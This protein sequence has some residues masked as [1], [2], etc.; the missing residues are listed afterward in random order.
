MEYKEPSIPKELKNQ[1]GKFEGYDEIQRLIE[2]NDNGLEFEPKNETET[3]I[4]YKLNLPNPEFDLTSFLVRVRSAVYKKLLDEIKDKGSFRFYLVL[5]PTMVKDS[6]D[7]K[8]KD[9]LDA[10]FPGMSSK[11]Q[12]VMTP[13]N[14]PDKVKNAYDKIK[15]SVENFVN[16]GSNWRLFSVGNIELVT[17]RYETGNG[18]PTEVRPIYTPVSG[19][20]Y[21]PSPKWIADKKAVVNVRNE[22]NKCFRWALKSALFPVQKHSCRTSQYPCNSRDGLDFKGFEFPMYVS[23]IPKFEKRNNLAINVFGEDKWSLKA[24]K[25]IEENIEPKM[26]IPLHYSKMDKNIP[27]INLLLI[28]NKNGGHYTWIRNFSRLFGNPSKNYKARYYCTHCLFANYDSKA[29]MNEHMIDCEGPERAACRIEMPEEGK[30]TLKFVNEHKKMPV[31]YVI[32]AD[33]ECIIQKVPHAI[34]S[35]EKS[36][37]TVVQK[38]VACG[39]CYIVVKSD[40]TTFP[41]VEY[42]GEN[43]AKHFVKSIVQAEQQIKKIDPMPLI[44]TEQ[45]EKNFHNATVCHICCKPFE[46]ENIDYEDPYANPDEVEQKK[47]KKGQHKVRDHCHISGDYRGAAHSSCNLKWRVGKNGK[48][49]VFFHNL[50]NY[51]A[52][53]IMQEIH[54]AYGNISCIANNTEKYISFSVGNLQFVDSFQF[55]STSLARLADNT[56]SSVGIKGMKILQKWALHDKQYD[57]ESPDLPDRAVTNN[58]LELLTRKGVYPYDAMDDWSCFEWESLPEKK[59]FYSILNKTDISDEDYQHEQEVFKAFKCKNMG[60]YCDLYCR[61]DVLL[62]AEIFENYRKVCLDIYKLDPRYFTSPGLSWDALLLSSGIELELLTDYDKFM[63]VENG[64]RGGISMTSKRYARAN[65]PM[66]PDYDPNKPKTWLMYLDANNLYGWAMSQPMPTG[67][68]RWMTEEEIADID[69]GVTIN[70]IKG[71]SSVGA[72]FCNIPA[73][74]KTG[75]ILQVDLEY[76]KELHD[77]HNSYPLAPETISTQDDWVSPYQREILGNSKVDKIRK[78]IPNLRDKE[79]Y[80]IHYKNLALYTSLGL[81]CKKIHRVLA[82]NQKPWMEPYIAKNTELRKKTKSAFEKDLFKLMNNSVYGKTMEN[83]RKRI[84][85]R[86][87]KTSEKEKM[88]RMLANPALNSIVHFSKELLGFKLNKTRLFLNKPIYIGFCVLEL[89]KWLMYDFYYNNL[90]EKYGDKVQVLYTDT[91]SLLLEIE[92]EDA[93]KDIEKDIDSYDTSDYDQEH[94]LHSTKNKKVVGKM[95][96]EMA[97]KP[98]HEY[99]GLRSKMYSILTSK[100]HICKAKGVSKATIREIMHDMY[101]ESLKS[102]KTFIHGMK[103]IRSTKHVI[104]MKHLNKISIS[105]LDTKRWICRD[106]INTLAYGNCKIPQLTNGDTGI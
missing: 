88:I 8:K 81:V 95:K 50:R 93:Y 77:S 53:L 17:S 38:Q 25:M 85:F 64:I 48:I 20:R 63:F 74:S 52:H 30:N 12:I 76:P 35:P 3:S 97:G 78:L 90:V 13:K 83:L 49:P 73:D 21:I 99:V 34:P 23:E 59:D 106:H 89:S 57:R 47:K 7:N 84:D 104:E 10:M 40:G 86:V 66:V 75:Y 102:S 92:T 43:A 24:R 18:S 80:T 16:N 72:G 1:Q 61:T 82:F 91:D 54:H 103:Q 67:R 31:P 33:F 6:E 105:P 94:Y 22:D 5:K 4:R 101:L 62:L 39:F 65:N 2:E 36:S 96:D 41:P 45:D 9:G 56:V 79:K 55:L 19:S 11:T 71:N 46:N 60:D 28:Q 42:R 69:K 58:L 14:I 32:Y 87:V 100:K 15:S 44:M 37:T 51:D 98:I 70:Q 26:I 29:K 27:R 68:F